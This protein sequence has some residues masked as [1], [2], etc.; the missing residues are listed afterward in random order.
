VVVAA[1]VHG[2]RH[3]REIAEWVSEHR[4]TLAMRPTAFVSVSLSAAED[5]AEARADARGCIDRFVEDTGW[6][7]TVSLPVAGA[8]RLSAYDLP[9][10]V[11]MRLIA[12]RHGRD[13]DLLEDHDYTD[14]DALERFGR[15]FAATI[16]HAREPVRGA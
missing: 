8:L 16:R 14:W 15:S 6:S 12:R 1:S 9:T 11:L 3:Q 13:N 10:R 4:T 5:S 2:G 7:P